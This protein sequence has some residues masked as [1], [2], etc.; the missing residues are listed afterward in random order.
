M[1]GPEQHTVNNHGEDESGNHSVPPR[2]GEPVWQRR[3]VGVSQNPKVNRST[4]PHRQPSRKWCSPSCE[5][6]AS[7]GVNL[8][9]RPDAA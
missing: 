8:S 6:P 7:A 2:L 1:K 4:S 9:P 5:V 3:P